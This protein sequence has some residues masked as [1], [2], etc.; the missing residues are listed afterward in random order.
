MILDLLRTRFSTRSFQDRPIATSILQDMLEAGRLSPSGGNEQAWRF[1]VITDARTVARVAEAAYQ[2]KWIAT[3]PLVI[4]LCTQEVQDDNGGRDIQAQRF[5]ELADAMMS[6]DAQLYSAL[7]SEE[8]QTKIPGVHMA[9][10]AL[11]H[12]IGC[13]WVSRFVVSSVARIIDVPDG[14]FPSEILVFGYPSNL[15]RHAP[16]KP[17]EESYRNLQDAIEQQSVEDRTRFFMAVVRCEDL[18]I[19]GDVGITLLDDGSGS[20]GWFIRRKYWGMGYA[21]EAAALMINCG[22]EAIG[23]DA[24]HASCRRENIRSERVMQKLGFR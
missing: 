17:L 21:S 12:G 10:A 5:P 22:F 4:V 14:Y 6:M 9:L 24:I 11:E 3:A 2:Q 19:V 1:G 13:T 8:H 16:K 18:E 15:G 7:N 20:I 23:L